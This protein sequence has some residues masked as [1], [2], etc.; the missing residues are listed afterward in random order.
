[1]SADKG[2]RWDVL[3]SD[4]RSF[5]RRLPG[6][7]RQDPSAIALDVLGHFADHGRLR[8]EDQPEVES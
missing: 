5:F 7:F 6:L 2:V 8:F 4:I 1:M 3:K